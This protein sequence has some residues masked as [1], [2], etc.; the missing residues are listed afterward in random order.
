MTATYRLDIYDTSGVL[1]YQLTDFT[2]LS[3]LRMV[4][5][6]GMVQ[7]VVAGDHD[8]LEH[9]ADKWQ[10]EVWR[11]AEDTAT[12]RREITGIC[13]YDEW[14]MGELSHG[15]IIAPGLMS[16]LDWRI[17][18]YKADTAN[19]SKF[20]NVAAET[21]ANT[22]VKYNATASGTTG[23]GRIRL[24]TIG[25]LSVEADGGAGNKYDWY[26]S[27]DNLLESLKALCKLG[28]GDFDLV[29]TSSTAWQ[30]RWYEGQLGTDKHTTVIFAMERGNMANP[31]Y[32]DN[33]TDE[34]TV[35]IVGGQGEGADRNVVV[36][37]GTNY[38]VD[39]NN[40][41]VFLYATD[42]ETTAA[43]N[44]RGDKRL[45]EMQAVK[46]FR[47]DVLQT[48]GCQYGTHYDLG[49]LVTAINPKTGAAY[50]VKVQQVRVSLNDD[51]SESISVEMSE[52][53]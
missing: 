25:G 39:S 13:R 47:F 34:A 1:Q 52:P 46:S 40:I 49:D 26:C 44:T 43:L 4:N 38:N 5:S 22:L 8:L 3:Y 7:F 30:W 2:A 45:K 36:R 37:T 32:V 19:R 41:E 11:R 17:V 31:Q 28:D 33:R 9:I 51:G 14:N 16:M 42:C 18:G 48:E 12:W 23:D 27:F 24:A 29:K 10:I 15:I 50:T 6:P 20:T 53:L 35:C 21:I